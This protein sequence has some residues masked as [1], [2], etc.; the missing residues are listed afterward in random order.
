[1][2]EAGRLH[3]KLLLSETVA[4]EEAG[5]VLPAMSNYDTVGMSVIT[6]F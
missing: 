6:H 3:P 4:L 1:M 5:P 2:V